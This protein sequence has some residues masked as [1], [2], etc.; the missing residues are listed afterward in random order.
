[1]TRASTARRRASTL[2]HATV[3]I[4]AR[5]AVPRKTVARAYISGTGSYLPERVMTNE[6]V[7]RR[8]PTTDEW[9]R[10][11]LGI[12]SRRIARED[13]QTSDLAVIA[14][15]NA[16]AAA[17][18]SPDDVDG[19]ICSVGVGD[20]P[21]P[22]T[23][24]YIQEKLGIEN[25]CFAFDIKMACAGA[26]GGV[27]IARGLVESGLAR[28]VVVAGT[29]VMSRTILD[30][31]DRTTAPIFGDGA[32]A[33]IVSTS[34][35][36]KTGVLVS[37]LHADGSLTG[38]VGQF[39]GGTQ[40][41]YT[42]ELVRD[43]KVRL[44][45]D[46]RAVWDCAVTVLPEVIQEVVREGGVRV[47]DIDFVVSHQANK[48]LLLHVLERSNIPL[49]KTYT[50]IEKYG[51]TSAASALI[52]LDECV[53]QGLVKSGQLI[54]FMAIGAGMIWGAHLIRW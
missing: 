8:A 17:K 26:I 42:P 34:P 40:Q 24:C 37:K 38:I 30:W 28:H 53:R 32:G 10:N 27:M 41:W 3:A 52:A 21:V 4:A 19:I 49:S 29:Q 13:Q 46:G 35:D 14:I 5:K 23:A 47:E 9:I 6:E 7:C 15:Q 43:G 12:E 22:A 33:A 39:V 25:K 44:E 48:R 36:P 54:L 11:K 18:L 51:N 1:L 31:T 16:L 20:V 45:M 50:N 2:A